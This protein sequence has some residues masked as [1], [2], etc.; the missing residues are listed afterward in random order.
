MAFKSFAAPAPRPDLPAPRGGDDLTIAGVLMALVSV[1]GR[2]TRAEY[3]LI[4]FGV[5]VAAITL[6]VA[7]VHFAGLDLATMQARPSPGLLWPAQA[8]LSWMMIAV[9]V[10]RLRDRGWPTIV[11]VGLFVGTPLVAILAVLAMPA[12]LGLVALAN[13]WSFIE[14]GFLDSAD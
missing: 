6:V 8:L 7:Y 1:R 12:L 3:W 5:F 2:A 4:S 9:T 14:C 13:L 11:P 10:R